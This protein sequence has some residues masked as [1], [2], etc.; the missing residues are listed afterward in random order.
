MATDR[1][2]GLMA[3]LRERTRAMHARA[4][5]SGIVR[6]ILRGRVSRY[7]Y[8]LLLRNLLPAYREIERGLRRHRDRP[9]ISEIVRPE[10]VRVQAIESDLEALFGADW[11]RKLRPLRSGE[12][13]ALRIARAE[14]DPE[15][16]LAHP[17]VRYLGDLNGGQVLRRMLA[18]SPGF[19][20]GM[21]A[22][23]AFPNIRDVAKFTAD[24][25]DALDRA[26]GKIAAADRV[27]GEALAAFRLNI[28]LFEAVLRAALAVR[29]ASRRTAHTSHSG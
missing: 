24:Y 23:H 17:Y 22:F 26:G 27:I 15:M 10:L 18:R 20:P 6:E 19:G 1:H 25:R 9:A 21:L 12:L 13:Y 28:R 29:R 8:A 5:R 11:C 14:L 4:E 3:A 16:L 7:G 2:P